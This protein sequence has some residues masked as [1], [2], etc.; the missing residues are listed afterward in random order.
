VRELKP[1][2]AQG[3]ARAGRLTGADGQTPLWRRAPSQ[4]TRDLAWS[5]LSPPLLSRLPDGA[6]VVRVAQWPAG[7]RAAWQD[8][9]A[10]ADPS[11]LPR[12]SPN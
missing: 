9:L 1:D 4:R 7:V 10:Q 3:I 8:W 12:P 11:T 2:L 5:S 6:D